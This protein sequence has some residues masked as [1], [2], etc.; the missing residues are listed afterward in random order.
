MKTQSL[1]QKNYLKA[2]ESAP[3]VK[4]TLTIFEFVNDEDE[5]DGV[6]RK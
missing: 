4:F 5:K 1:I 6:A 3:T 2:R